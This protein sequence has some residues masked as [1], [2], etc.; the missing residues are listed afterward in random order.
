MLRCIH[1]VD[2]SVIAGVMVTQLLFSANGSF[3]KTRCVFMGISEAPALHVQSPARI[4]S[5]AADEVSP[6]PSCRGAPSQLRSDSPCDQMVPD[7]N[8]QTMKSFEHWQLSRD[9]IRE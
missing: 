6:S 8:L 9:A 7:T 5:L 3:G 2:L 1:W 4:M